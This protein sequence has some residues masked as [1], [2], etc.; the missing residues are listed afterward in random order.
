MIRPILLLASA[1]LAATADIEA[2]K[3]ATA[4]A[5]PLDPG[6]VELAVGASWAVADAS[7]GRH[8]CLHDRGG[9]QRVTGVGI[10]ATVGLLDGLDAGVGIGWTWIEDEACDPGSGSGPTDLELGAKWRCWSQEGDDAAWAIA[11]L[12][13][14]TTPLGD[15][16]DPDREIPTASRCW[17]AGLCVAGSGSIGTV[18]INADL[19]YVHALGDGQERDGYVGTCAANAAIGVQMSAGLQPELDLSWAGDVVEDGTAPW[20]LALTAGAQIAL[21]FGRLGLGAQRVLDGSDT[22]RA[23]VLIA[24]LAIACE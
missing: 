14:V 3:L 1:A 8:G 9:T 11:L 13:G 6:A 20:S 7:Y 19:G 18:A 15:G 5:A 21:P 10:G 23:T 12:P 24:D 22:D 16:Q 17:T 2:A 4:D